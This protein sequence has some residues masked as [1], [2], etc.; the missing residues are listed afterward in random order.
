MSAKEQFIELMQNVLDDLK[1]RWDFYRHAAY[2]KK[3]GLTEDE[4][5]EYNDPDRNISATRIKDYYHGY[6]YWVI[7]TTSRGDPWTRFGTWME[8]FTEI[9]DW[10]KENCQDKWRSDIHRVIKEPSTANQWEM[11][12]IGGGDALFF[13][14]KNQEDCFLFKLKWGGE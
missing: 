13:A 4:Y 7:F 8:G 14:F 9:K 10:C 6:P 1:S 5:Q 3:H 12:D 2:L 11:N